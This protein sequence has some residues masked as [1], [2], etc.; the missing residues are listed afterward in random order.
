VCWGARLNFTDYREVGVKGKAKINERRPEPAGSPIETGE[1]R[2]N[3]MLY[4]VDFNCIDGESA[5][6]L[7]RRL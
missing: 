7:E 2:K 4:E 3:E 5:G 1:N 6:V